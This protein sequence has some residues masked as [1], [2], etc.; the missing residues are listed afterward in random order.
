METQDAVPLIKRKGIAMSIAMSNEALCK[1]MI[2]G[3]FKG[4]VRTSIMGN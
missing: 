3:A 2:K 4:R 1:T